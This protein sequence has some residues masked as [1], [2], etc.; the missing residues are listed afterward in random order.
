MSMHKY[1]INLCWSNVDKVYVA[2]VPELPGCMADGDTL[3][4]ALKSAQEAIDLWLECAEELGRQIP[5]AKGRNFLSKLRIEIERGED[6]GYVAHCTS[7]PGCH[8]QGDTI[9]EALDNIQD[10]IGGCLDALG[11]KD[12]TKEP[13]WTPEKNMD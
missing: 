11:I 6:F 7:I 10:A 9:E 2:A 4:D 13:P 8:S 3:E 1:D 12:W 5:E